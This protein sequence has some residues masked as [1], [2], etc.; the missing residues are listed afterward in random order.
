MVIC[1]A[2][3]WPDASGAE[4]GTLARPGA[5]HYAQHAALTG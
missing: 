3:G 4:Q 1:P 2:P 5:P